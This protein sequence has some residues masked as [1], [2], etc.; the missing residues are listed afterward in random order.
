LSELY[1]LLSVYYLPD[2][3]QLIQQ[4]FS[5]IANGVWVVNV[6][7]TAEINMLTYVVI[8][9]SRLTEMKFWHL[10]LFIGNLTWQRHVV[11]SAFSYNTMRSMCAVH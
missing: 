7:F 6:C 9:C 11:L 8:A 1:L 5:L 10:V 4:Y 2:F 3:K